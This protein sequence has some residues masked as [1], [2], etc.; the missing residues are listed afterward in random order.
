MDYQ[1]RNDGGIMI[2]ESSPKTSKKKSTDGD[3]D[4]DF[5]PVLREIGEFGRYQIIYY[6]MLCIPI[7]IYAGITLTYVFT[8]GNLNYR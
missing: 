8:A 7:A 6:V 1:R 2:S 3:H 4:F 5:D